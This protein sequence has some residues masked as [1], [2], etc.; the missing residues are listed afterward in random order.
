[1]TLI[2]IHWV[3]VEKVDDYKYFGVHDNKLDF[4]KNTEGLCFYFQRWLSSFYSCSGSF[5][6]L[7]WTVPCSLL[8]CARALH[9]VWWKNNRFSTL[10]RMPVPLWVRSLTVWQRLQK[11][12]GYPSYSQYWR[13]CKM[14]PPDFIIHIYN[15]LL[16]FLNIKIGLS[17]WML[18]LFWLRFECRNMNSFYMA[19]KYQYNF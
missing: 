18:Y 19:N 3:C 11:G 2:F 13:V 6:S 8:L 4:I 17:D 5:M 1:M 15:S 14:W 9:W 10:I 12:G 7:C 16:S